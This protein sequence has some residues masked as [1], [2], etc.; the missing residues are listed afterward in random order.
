[1]S[2]IHQALTSGQVYFS[3]A[4]TTENLVYRL[5]AQPLPKMLPETINQLIEKLRHAFIAGMSKA[6]KFFEGAVYYQ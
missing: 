1:M 4:Y 6:R 3:L 5:S 2:D